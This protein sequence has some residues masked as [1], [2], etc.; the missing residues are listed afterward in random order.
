MA[1]LVCFHAHPDD[2]AHRHRRHDGRGGRRRPPGGARARH[3]GRA[4]RAGRPACSPRASRSGSAGSSRP[5]ASAEILGVERVEFLGYVDSGM[6]GEPTNDDPACFWQAD[7]EEAAEPPGRDPPRGATPTCSRSTTTTAATATPTTSRCTG[8]GAGPP[9]SSGSTRVYE[10]TMNRDA[11][12]RTM[13]DA[14]ESWRPRGRRRGASDTWREARSADTDEF[15]SP[16]ALITHAVDVSAVR[17]PQ[18]ARRWWPTPA[19]SPPTR[20]SSRCP[21]RSSRWRSAPSGSSARPGTRAP[22]DPF[23]ASIARCPGSPPTRG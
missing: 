9:S 6:M 2:E 18:E 20:S 10:S 7:V 15:G 16:E 22:G 4:R 12:R 3:P 11:I 14:A 5:T 21:R 17:R 13:E 1:T 8:S 23:V 19:R